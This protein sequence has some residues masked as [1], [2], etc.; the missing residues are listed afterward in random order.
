MEY[1][2]K[3]KLPKNAISVIVANSLVSDRFIQLAPA[4]SGPVPTLPDGA[5][6]PV[7]R[8]ASPAEL[9]DI[10]SALN[11]LSVSLGPKGANKTAAAR[12]GQRDGSEPAGQRPR[13]ARA[14]PSSRRPPAPS[15]S[16]GATCSGTV[17]N[18]QAF[19]KALS[20]SDVQVRHFNEQLA[21]GSRRIWP[22]SGPIWGRPCT[23]SATAL[24]QVADIREV[25]LARR[26]SP[27]S[28]G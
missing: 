18:L 3:Y 24:N 22:T 27:T 6:L 28:P 12:S 16:G 26:R 13:W 17:K 19:T 2:S 5:T 1:D 7:S 9:D 15:H 20:D 10:Y 4:Y 23:T 11:K 8:T 21:P 25:E 14:S